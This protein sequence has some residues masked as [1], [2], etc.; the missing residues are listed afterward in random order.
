MPTARLFEGDLSFILK[1]LEL[2]DNR[3]DSVGSAISV[4]L[5]EIRQVVLSAQVSLPEWPS[6]PTGKSAVNNHHQSALC[7]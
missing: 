2:F 4:I 5:N 3:I 6:L 7:K 1:K